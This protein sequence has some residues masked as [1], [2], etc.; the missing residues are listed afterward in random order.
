VLQL[1]LD[2][3]SDHLPAPQSVQPSELVVAAVL[4]DF[5]PAGHSWAVQLVLT[6]PIEKFPTVQLVHPSELLVATERVEY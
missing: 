1:V 2:P 4:V 5:C 6:P 3:V